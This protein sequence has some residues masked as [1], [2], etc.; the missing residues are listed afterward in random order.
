[1]K[2]KCPGTKDNCPHLFQICIKASS[3]K[4]IEGLMSYHL[5]QPVGTITGFSSVVLQDEPQ[6]AHIWS[7]V[8]RGGESFPLPSGCI[9]LKPS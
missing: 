4:I 1:M 7:G 8:I 2:P 5:N 3:G 6:D 9:V